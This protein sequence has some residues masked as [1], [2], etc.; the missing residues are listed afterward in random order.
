MK[1][2]LIVCC[3]LLVSA[4]ALGQA[5]SPGSI[6]I[7]S[8]LG[9]ADC[10]IMD[11]APGVVHV[12]IVHVYTDGATESSFKLESPACNMM[13]YIG[14]ATGGIGIPENSVL[15]G[16]GIVYGECMASPIL[17]VTVEFFATGLSPACC[18][19]SMVAAPFAA[20]GRIEALDCNDNLMFPSGG[21]A[22]INPLPDCTCTYPVHGNT[23]GGIKSLYQ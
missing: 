13:T 2:L 9:Y 6:D 21:Q 16:I 23:W 4:N 7:F 18:Y 15:D 17:L 19:L 1:V 12:Y 22:I 20:S 11:V 8:D 3:S 10:A 14:E 5:S